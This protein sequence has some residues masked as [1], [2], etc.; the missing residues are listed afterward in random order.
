MISPNSEPG[1]G[2]QWYTEASDDPEVLAEQREVCDLESMSDR[3]IAALRQYTVAGR[4]W[5]CGNQYFDTDIGELFEL[6]AVVRKSSWCSTKPAE[7]GTVKL[8]FVGDR[9]G[10]LLYDPQSMDE[11]PT[12]RFI[13]RYRAPSPLGAPEY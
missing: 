8:Q 12:E 11:D 5:T 3:E 2:T 6:V 7:E 13:E 4:V 10:E 9:F 1:T